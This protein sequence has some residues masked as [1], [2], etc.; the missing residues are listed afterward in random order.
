MIEKLHR[1]ISLYITGR[2][3]VAVMIEKETI[4][5]EKGTVSST[6]CLFYFTTLS[7][8]RYEYVRVSKRQIVCVCERECLCVEREIVCVLGRECVCMRVRGSEGGEKE[9]Q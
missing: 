1:I 2:E 9:K 6:Y 3:G 5:V 8:L 4:E 7:P